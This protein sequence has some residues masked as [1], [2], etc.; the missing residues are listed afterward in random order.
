MSN[1]SRVTVVGWVGTEPTL[2]T[3]ARGVDFTSFRLGVTRRK[4][5]KETESWENGETVWYTVKAWRNLARNIVSSISK[6]DP[7]IVSGELS[8]DEWQSEQGPRSSIVIEAES[9]GHNLALGLAAFSLRKASSNFVDAQD[10]EGELA[11]TQFLESEEEMSAGEKL[12]SA[13]PF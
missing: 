10:V 6:S 4:F 2:I 7:V 1:S 12:V 9:V 11:E 8:V 5:Q 13:A 3:S